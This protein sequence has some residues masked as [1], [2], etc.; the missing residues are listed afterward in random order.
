MP[1]TWTKRGTET[2]KSDEGGG[3]VSGAMRRREGA[4][5]GG[6]HK[7]KRGEGGYS[8]EQK[9]EEKRWK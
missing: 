1:P 6:R 9:R 4:R 7:C 2:E 3:S 8:G 5:G